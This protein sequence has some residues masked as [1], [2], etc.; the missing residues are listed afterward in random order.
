MAA[1]LPSTMK[2]WQYTDALGGLEKALHLNTSASLPPAG[3]S[4]GSE[5]VLVKV[6]YASLNPVDYKFPEVPIVDRLA[7]SKPA[8]P[9]LDYAGR[10]VAVGSHGKLNVGQ[11]VFGK[12]DNPK[13][14]FGTL[15]EYTV[16]PRA[17]TVP[18]P[19]GVSAEDAACVGVAGLTAYQCIAP[20]VKSGENVFINGGSGGTGTFGIQIAKALGCHV[21]VTCSGANEALCRKLGADQVI[22]YREQDPVEALKS[23]GKKFDLVVD[24]VG[25]NSQLYYQCH[26]FTKATAKY[27]AV[28][29]QP[30]L[31][32][33]RDLVTR[34][35]WPTWL[36]GG[37]RKFVF[38]MAS[39]DYD[40]YAQI[41]QWMAEGK[42]KPVIDEV[43]A[44]EDVPNAFEKLKTGRAKGKVVVK[45][46]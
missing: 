33:L 6:E 23:S 41:G 27:V 44:M 22:D 38:L 3:A 10:V 1:S 8:T 40:A 19:D 45:V 24:N 17:G 34:F 16:T 20:N 15:A 11:M 39:T 30:G 31:G 13:Q 28:G 32:A 26:H 18:V 2:A 9:G 25:M 21:T 7:I 46:H 37:Q 14:Q 43:F 4:L 12:L 36:G 42:V 35:I 5:Q 29:M